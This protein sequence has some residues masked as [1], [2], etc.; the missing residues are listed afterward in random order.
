MSSKNVIKTHCFCQ[1]RPFFTELG[2]FFVSSCVNWV[3]IERRDTPLA[4]Y[5]CEDYL[6]YFSLILRGRFHLQVSCRVC[7]WRAVYV[8]KT[9]LNGYRPQCP[10]WS[11]GAQWRLCACNVRHIL[12]LPVSRGFGS[13]RDS[14]VCEHFRTPRVVSSCRTFARFCLSTARI[15]PFGWC[16]RR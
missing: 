7:E 4:D 3:K 8:P 13:L 6:T 9:V 1:M 12:L 2:L 14:R 10:P 11:G 5:K 16:F 15:S